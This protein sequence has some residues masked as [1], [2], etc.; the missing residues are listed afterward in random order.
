MF[1]ILEILT[2]ANVKKK[3]NKNDKFWDVMLCVFGCLFF[4][5]LYNFILYFFV[6]EIGHNLIIIGVA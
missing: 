1:G 4:I 5:V 2:I 6:D 3:K